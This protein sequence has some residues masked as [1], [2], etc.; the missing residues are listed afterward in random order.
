MDKKR[1]DTRFQGGNNAFED[2]QKPFLKNGRLMEDGK[3]AWRNAVQ[4]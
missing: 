3:S 4:T 2:R 1:V